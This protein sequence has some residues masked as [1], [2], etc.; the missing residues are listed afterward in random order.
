MINFNNYKNI[1]FDFDG[2][3][4]DTN[5]LKESN[6]EKVVKKYLNPQKCKLCLQHFNSNPGIPR[7]IKLKK[8]IQDRKVLNN[9]LD[10]YNKLNMKNLVNSKFVFGVEDFLKKWVSQNLK[11]FVLSGAD[12]NE[13]KFI[14]ENKKIKRFFNYIG[15]GPLTKIDHLNNLKLSGK[16]IY[17]GD[18]KYDNFVA[19]KFGFDFIFVNGYTS[20]RK[21]D[22][23]FDC[24]KVITNFDEI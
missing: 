21:V 9:I 10:D 8:H 15:G 1:I 13:L 18:S 12:Q 17:F 7:E 24:F 22:L 4:L 2:V 3:I 6:I 14:I 20:I 11:F 5:T 19:N 23:E 16:S